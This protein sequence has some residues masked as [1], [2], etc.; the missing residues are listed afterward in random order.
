MRSATSLSPFPT[1]LPHFFHLTSRFLPLGPYATISVE[2]FDAAHASEAAAV[3][4]RE[5][6]WLM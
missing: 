2:K 5:Q 1:S 6:K 3:F 4:R